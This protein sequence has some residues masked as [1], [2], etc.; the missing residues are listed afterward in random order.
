MLDVI[1]S[2]SSEKLNKSLYEK[3]FNEKLAD[4]T[5]HHNG[6][7]TVQKIL[8]STVD[9]TQVLYSGLK[10][11]NNIKICFIHIFSLKQCLIN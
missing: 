4:L 9:V 2:E 1:I 10:Y 5:V 3:Y 11:L 8:L 7:F 6:N